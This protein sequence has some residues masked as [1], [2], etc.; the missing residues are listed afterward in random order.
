MARKK[1]RKRK[2]PIAGLT[3]DLVG[4]GKMGITAGVTGA[5]AG[6]TLAHAGPAAAAAVPI[7]GGF[8]TVAGF[9]GPVALASGGGRALDAVRNLNVEPKRK[10]RKKMRYY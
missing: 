3:S 4:F 2:S 1:K 6:M 8:G 9:A 10:K 5:A 7:M